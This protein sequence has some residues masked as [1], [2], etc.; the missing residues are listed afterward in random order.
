MR[1]A[2]VYGY[3]GY[4]SDILKRLLEL[5]ARDGEIVFMY[6]QNGQV[7]EKKPDGYDKS[8][9]SMGGG[10]PA[11]WGTAAI[12]DA[13]VAGLAGVRD[14]DGQFAK[15]TFSPAWESLG[16]R[17]ARASVTF[18]TT[19]SYFAYVYSHSPDKR[20]M[21]FRVASDKACAVK[22]S[23]PVPPGAK[24]TQVLVNGKPVRFAV[25]TVSSHFDFDA[26]SRSRSSARRSYADF[27]LK[28]RQDA[29]RLDQI[30][31]VYK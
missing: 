16:S 26:A 1:G 17:Q 21:A 23:I 27:T 5:E 15:L 31:V 24:P 10:G 29:S 22:A 20:R 8:A 9:L 3:E 6:D 14:I 30:T 12:Y 11:G 25:R 7:F 13:M 19:D 18:A 28:L 2:Y 4:G